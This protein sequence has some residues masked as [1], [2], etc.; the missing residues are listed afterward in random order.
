MDYSPAPSERV[1][2][3]PVNPLSVA[4][5][6][7]LL[8]AGGAFGWRMR[9]DA[10]SA[11]PTPEAAAAALALERV[12]AAPMCS[13]GGHDR[14]RDE[15]LRGDDSADAPERVGAHLSQRSPLA[16]YSKVS[17][18]PID[19]SSETEFVSGAVDGHV[20]SYRPEG[21]GG[22]DLYAFRFL[23]RRAAADAV[24]DNV[25]QRVCE[26]GAVPLE[27]RGRPGMIVVEEDRRGEWWSAWWL[28][29]SDVLVVR[30]FPASPGDQKT[31][32]VNLA[33]IAGAT[34]LF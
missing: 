1:R 5:A 29:G 3:R 23:T 26:F 16:G 32:L 22:F 7:V 11:R 28:T 10:P 31:S 2:L 9:S 30:Y 15:V 6:V 12:D 14:V 4:V 33:A 20:V 25:R 17:S 8:C 34:A 19:A 13:E 18:H 27:A 21:E 24:A